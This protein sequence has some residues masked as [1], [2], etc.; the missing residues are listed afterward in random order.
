MSGLKKFSP[1]ILRGGC[2]GNFGQQLQ[3]IMIS[4]KL[5]EKKFGLPFRVKKF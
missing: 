3:D 2:G 1:A 5:R 4:G